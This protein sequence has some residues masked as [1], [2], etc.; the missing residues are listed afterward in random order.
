VLGL[1]VRTRRAYLASLH[2][3]AIRAERERDQQSQIAAAR[4]IGYM[5]PVGPGDE[6]VLPQRSA[7]PNRDGLLADR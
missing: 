5:P 3:R 6:I 1:N 7:N 4:E 2:D